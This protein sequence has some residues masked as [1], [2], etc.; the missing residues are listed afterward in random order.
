MEKVA[1]APT[2]LD[3]KAEVGLKLKTG[4]ELEMYMQIPSTCLRENNKELVDP[5]DWCERIEAHRQ[6]PLL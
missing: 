6:C 2:F 1:A 4:H 3:N 5:I